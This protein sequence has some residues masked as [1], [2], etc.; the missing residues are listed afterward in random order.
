M[1]VLLSIE[2]N[3]GSGKSTIVTYLQQRCKDSKIIFLQEPVN[4]W[5]SIKDENDES[6]LS[7]FYKNNK[8]YAF[9][10][11]MMAYISR[12][13]A[14]KDAID[15]NPDSIIITERSLYTDK[16]VFAKMLHDVGDMN[17]IDYTIYNKWFNAF[18]DNIPHNGII[19]MKTDPLKCRMR[20]VNRN[21]EGEQIDISYLHMCHEYHEQWINSTSVP[22]T[23]LDGNMDINLE[24]IDTFM[25]RIEDTITSYTRDY[26]QASQ[27]HA[28]Y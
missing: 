10:F 17:K 27:Q 3:I 2:G 8:Q 21:R 11:Q 26:G 5:E 16:H 15:S 7:L 20:I 25:K 6:I 1:V 22:V 24:H 14:I 9:S 4:E 13:K 23:V 28:S 19:Y 18:V 12:L